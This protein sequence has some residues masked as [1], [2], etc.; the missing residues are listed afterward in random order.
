MDPNDG[1][2]YPRQYI[3]G[4]PYNGE[5]AGYMP[6]DYPSV[7]TQQISGLPMAAATQIRNPY[8]PQTQPQVQYT[9]AQPQNPGQSMKTKGKRRSKNET[10]GRNYKCN[11]CDRTYLSYPALYTHIKT[12]HSVQGEAPMTS[13]RGRGRPKKNL[14]KEERADP[15]SMLYFRTEEHKGGPTA[16]LYGFKEA[17]NTLFKDNMKYK[18]FDEHR[19]YYELYKRHLKN[20]DTLN[21]A[22]EH[23]NTIEF[24]PT[25]KG[26]QVAVYV[27]K[28]EEPP[29]PSEDA[30]EAKE[31]S[32]P[33]INSPEK[34]QKKCDEVFAEYLDIVAKEVNKNCY[35]DV[36]K[37]VFLFRE[38]LNH[39]GEKLMKGKNDDGGQDQVQKNMDGKEEYCLTHN[40]E[41]APEISNE[42]VTVYLDE[43][44]STFGN[45]DPIEL[46][47]NFC[48]WLFSNGYTCS[49]LSL[50]QDNQ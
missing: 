20:V 32:S 36:L 44:K 8:F 23:P 25:P 29:K 35:A 16:V 50:I 48:G 4:M 6:S 9:S 40:P 21:Y 31:N 41:Q 47:Q 39:Y 18:S 46:T 43:Q 2:E 7:P 5:F 38:C 42:F 45:M 28:T 10:E 19:L 17:Y 49:K 15:T 33:E 11:Q 24:G 27:L 14:A 3:P 13:G 37:F 34:K 12:K 26:L 30:S 22:H 1:K